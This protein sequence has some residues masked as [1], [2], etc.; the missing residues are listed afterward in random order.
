[1]TCEWRECAL[2]QFAEERATVRGGHRTALRRI[3]IVRIT[4]LLCCR[5]AR[6]TSAQDRA[7]LSARA[8]GSATVSAENLGYALA[9]RA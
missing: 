7:S 4:V 5:Y 1:M 2:A 6:Y 8:A 3:A 9:I